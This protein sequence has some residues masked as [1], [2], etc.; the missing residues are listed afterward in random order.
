[1]TNLGHTWPGKNDMKTLGSPFRSVS[2]IAENEIA[3]RGAWEPLRVAEGYG[4]GQAT[5]SVMR[6]CRGS[7]YRATGTA[8]RKN[9]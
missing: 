9:G 2:L 8:D 6:P 4:L 7:R 1:M 5:I 3:L